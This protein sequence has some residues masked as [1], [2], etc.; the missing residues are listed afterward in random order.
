[1]IARTWN[2][3]VPAHHAD[4]FERH[5]LATGVA[6]AARLAGY[7]G[8]QILRDEANGHVEFRLI[9]YW[10]DWAAIRRFAG[11]ELTAAV[12]YPGDEAYELIPGTTV[13]HHLV[14]FGHPLTERPDAA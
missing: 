14:S 7:A 1:M 9:T 12:L 8:A 2:G 10:D 5:L 11:E 3:R 13:R 6:E 4:G